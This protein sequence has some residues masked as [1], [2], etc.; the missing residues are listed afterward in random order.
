M[1]LTSIVITGFAVLSATFGIKLFDLGGKAAD[2]QVSLSA[3]LLE[4][5]TLRDGFKEKMIALLPV[6]LSLSGTDVSTAQRLSF[7]S[8]DTLVV[9]LFGPD[10]PYSADNVPL[11]NR[12]HRSGVNVIG[13]G[14]AKARGPE[15]WAF[16]RDSG[17]DFPILV[18]PEGGVR[19]VLPEDAVPATAIILD[20]RLGEVWL[21]A[22]DDDRHDELHDLFRLNS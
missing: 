11:L 15:V 4:A 1:R 21:G 7:D 17:V 10:C 8:S 9:Y 13:L 5:E 6:P 14:P 16:G 22:L 19:E 20:G 2:L 12:L 3:D 18:D